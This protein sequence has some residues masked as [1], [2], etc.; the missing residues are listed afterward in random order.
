MLNNPINA[1]CPCNECGAK[2]NEECIDCLNHSSRIHY[3]LEN[4]SLQSRIEAQNW[5]YA[6]FPDFLKAM[7]MEEEDS[8]F[9][10]KEEY[11]MWKSEVGQN[12]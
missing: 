12:V 7:A 9:L 8:I 4:A 10:N 6:D 2:L 5:T 11:T 3:F 1:F